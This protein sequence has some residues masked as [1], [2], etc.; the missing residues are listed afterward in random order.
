MSL[1]WSGVCVCVCIGGRQ[2]G[3]CVKVIRYVGCC[4]LKTGNKAASLS[5]VVHFFFFFLSG[6]AQ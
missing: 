5:L 1:L 2:E 3:V 6:L 4:P